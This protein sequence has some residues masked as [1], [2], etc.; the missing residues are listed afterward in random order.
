MMA[1]LGFRTMDEMIGRVR[2]ARRPRG[3]GALE[4]ARAGPGAALHRPAVGPEVAIRKVVEQDHGLEKSLDMTTAG[5]ARAGRARAARAGGHPRCP[6]GTSTGRW[7]PCSATR[8]PRAT[9]PT[10][11]PTTRSGSTSRAR[12]ARA[13]AP[14]CPAASRCTL[15][16]DANDYVGKG[17]SGGKIDRLPAAGGDLRA[18]GEH[19]RGQR[20]ALRRHQRRGLLPRAWRASASRCGTAAPPPWWRAWATTAAST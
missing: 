7:A 11:C 5:A 17:L 12:R 20:G 10:A 4:G 16:G 1:G 19:P 3:R 9:A 14:S 2:P 6:S 8:S 13:S 18:G 15:E